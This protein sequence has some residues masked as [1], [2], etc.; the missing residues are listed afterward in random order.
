MFPSWPRG[1]SI[2]GRSKGNLNRSL[3]VFPRIVPGWR[4]T[5]PGLLEIAADERNAVR[6]ERRDVALVGRLSE[7]SPAAESAKGEHPPQAKSPVSLLHFAESSV[8]EERRLGAANRE[9][10]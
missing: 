6:K 8:I 3:K 4:E 7:G 5:P 9:S 2:V 1:S 10:R